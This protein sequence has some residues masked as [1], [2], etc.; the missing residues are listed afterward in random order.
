MKKKQQQQGK[1]G[2]TKQQKYNCGSTRKEK[3][4]YTNTYTPKTHHLNF[5]K[6]TKKISNIT[7]MN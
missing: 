1:P 7:D 6:Q 3:H 4:T 2:K 5:R